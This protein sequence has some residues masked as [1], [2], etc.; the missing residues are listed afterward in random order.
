MATTSPESCE[1]VSPFCCTL[2]SE[3]P[4]EFYDK[5]ACPF[6]RQCFNEDGE[7]GVACSKDDR[8]GCR[9]NDL[10]FPCDADDTTC[11]ACANRGLTKAVYEN[12][13]FCRLPV[14]EQ[15]SPKFSALCP[16]T[17]KTEFADGLSVH[18][19]LSRCRD[20]CSQMDSRVVCTSRNDKPTNYQK[21]DPYKFA[22][23]LNTSKQESVPAIPDATVACDGKACTPDFSK[24]GNAQP[25]T[26]GC[27]A[28]PPLQ[29]PY[30]PSVCA[31][32]N[33]DVYYHNNQPF[34]NVTWDASIDQFWICTTPHSADHDGGDDD[35]DDEDEDHDDDD[36]P[37]QDED[38][39][40]DGTNGALVDPC[41]KVR[42]VDCVNTGTCEWNNV[43]RMCYDRKITT[44]NM[45]TNRDACEQRSDC[46]FNKVSRHCENSW[47]LWLPVSAGIFFFVILLFSVYVFLLRGHV[48]SLQRMRARRVFDDTYSWRPSSWR[49]P[50]SRHRP[51]E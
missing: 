31:N 44:C 47:A 6:V 46:T 4:P 28:V 40:E 23:V 48:P 45:E 7:I 22:C 34:D 38:A 39:Q 14:G 27:V 35:D 10:A 17:V 20:F 29:Q 3:C 36:Q 18:E 50:R 42:P 41:R 49:W 1:P 33:H 2:A 12:K 32:A 25:D 37:S 24:M 26:N 16:Y 43:S 30:D 5:K 13:G 51:Y 11:F 8:P 21:Y 19:S 9:L 15:I